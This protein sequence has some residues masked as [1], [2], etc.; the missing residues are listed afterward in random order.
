MRSITRHIQRKVEDCERKKTEAERNRRNKNDLGD[1]TSKVLGQL[2]P[3]GYWV[4]LIKN[5][6]HIVNHHKLQEVVLYKRLLQSNALPISQF[7]GHPLEIFEGY[8]V[9]LKNMQYF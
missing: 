2:S 5:G 4:C 3:S 6:V 8:V 7:A 1:A 9:T